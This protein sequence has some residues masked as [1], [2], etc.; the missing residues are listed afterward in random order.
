M[1]FF[2]KEDFKI[3]FN[4]FCCVYG[5]GTLG[6]PASYARAGPVY[7]TIA[8]LFMGFVNICSCVAISKVMLAA[9][10]SVRTYGD[11]GEWVFGKIGRYV[12]VTAQFGVCL[13]VPCAFLVLGGTLLN[14]IVPDAFEPEIWS[15]IMAVSLLPVILTPT[16]KEG[17]AAALAGCL[18]TIFADGIAL[19]VV[20]D[21]IG[22]H[23]DVVHP[24]FIFKEVATVFGNLALA[25]SAAVLVP[26]L[27]REHSQPTRMPRVVG[28][29]MAFTAVLF[30]TI[31]C[32]AFSYVGCQIPGNL[33]FAING[34]ALNLNASRGTVVLAYMFMQ[35]HI[36]IAMAVILNPVLFIAERGILGMHKRKELVF[37]EESPAIQYDKADTPDVATTTKE[38]RPSTT[39]SVISLAGSEYPEGNDEELRAEYRG[40]GVVVKY[41]AL[42]ITIVAILLVFAILFKDHFIDISDFVGASAITVGCI[43]LPFIFYLK[44]FWHS[45]PLYQKVFAVF[46]ILFCSTTGAY[47]TYLSGK[48]LFT[49]SDSSVN[50]PYCPAEY[51]DMVY[52]NATYYGAN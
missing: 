44:V 36:T 11:I 8:L 18:G 28:C 13:L 34:T 20:A 12:V 32:V 38:H 17:A 46:V 4:F 40:A 23:P 16:M 45:I 24:D 14:G 49:D 7:A 25:Y 39:R 5:I 6:I 48:S 30:L 2:T 9:P 43:V 35:L 42:R 26:E 31:G 3:G 15:I 19:G 27:Q 51:A 22:S 41:M 52:T 10:K 33:L 50:F 29:T 47:V 1:P 21:K 37:D